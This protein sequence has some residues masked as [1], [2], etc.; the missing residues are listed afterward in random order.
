MAK[1]GARRSGRAVERA[2]FVGT[3]NEVMDKSGKEE[4]ERRASLDGESNLNGR[5]K[6]VTVTKRQDKKK[7]GDRRSQHFFKLFCEVLQFS[8]RHQVCIE[9]SSSLWTILE[10][11]FRHKMVVF[12]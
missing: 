3:E 5:T 10:A 12:F 6:F 7:H 1:G 4:A 8:T 9:R 2:V 11:E